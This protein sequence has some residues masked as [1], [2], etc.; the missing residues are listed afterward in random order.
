MKVFWH[1]LTDALLLYT[2]LGHLVENNAIKE[3]A[4]CEDIR[5]CF[6]K[7][8]VKPGKMGASLWR[9]YS[10]KWL[11]FTLKLWLF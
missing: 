3:E 9:E 10:K 11:V 8:P 2:F 5:V 6:Y 4:T 7:A 1:Y